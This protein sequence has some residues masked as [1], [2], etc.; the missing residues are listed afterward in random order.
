V[1]RTRQFLA[2]K[3]FPPGIVHTTLGLTGATG[4]AA[5][6]Y[7]TGEL[8]ALAAKGLM[9]DFAFGNTAS[10]ADAY[11][12][13]AVQPLDHRVFFQLDDPHGGRRIDS[14]T[15]LVP[16]FSSLATVCP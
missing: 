12:H 13:A 2:D 16:E 11:D 5:D 14:Y 7:K 1:E 8:A 3:K 4:A 15:T 6:T 10:D 9:P